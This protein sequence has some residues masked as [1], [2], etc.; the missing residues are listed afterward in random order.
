MIKETTERGEGRGNGPTQLI[1]P[2]FRIRPTKIVV[3][4]KGS[5]YGEVLKKL[6][7]DL[8]AELSASVTE[9]RR[10]LAGNLVMKL[11]K[12]ADGRKMT[13]AANTIVGGDKAKV[14]RGSLVVIEIKGLDEETETEQV[15]EAVDKE[16]GRN[17]QY[18]VI[19]IRQYGGGLRIALVE[20]SRGDAKTLLQ[21]R[22]IKFGW[23][24]CR[25]QE[26]QQKPVECSRCLG[27]GHRAPECK[28]ND[29]KDRCKRCNEKEH[30]EEGCRKDPKCALC[31]EK[32]ESPNHFRGSKGCRAL[33]EAQEKMASTAAQS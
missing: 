10:S 29:N 19:G 18:N 21:L 2:T 6:Q 31:A 15:Q 16:T 14:T 12:E 28:G 13:E 27:Y 1:K 5:T 4:T 3:E 17:G 33:Q 8:P 30:M 11:N 23:T 22:R 26:R 9:A 20:C 32:G 7:R 24:S 25:I